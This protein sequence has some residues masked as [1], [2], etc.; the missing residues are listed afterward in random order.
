[1]VVVLTAEV[2]AEEIAAAA[3]QGGEERSQVV[4]GEEHTRVVGQVAA[5][6]AFV[7][8]VAAEVMK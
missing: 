3:E 8:L 2:L 4:G 6:A 7:P 1:L 5:P